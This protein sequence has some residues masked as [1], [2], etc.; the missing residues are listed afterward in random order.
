MCVLLLMGLLKLTNF[1]GFEGFDVVP[2]G[3]PGALNPRAL[4]RY[5]L[6]LR[7]YGMDLGSTWTQSR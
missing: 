3:E 7:T 5:G 1:A 2:S 6:D 4:S